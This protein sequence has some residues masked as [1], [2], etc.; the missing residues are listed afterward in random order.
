MT[1]TRPAFFFFFLFFLVFT[2]ELDSDILPKLSKISHVKGNVSGFSRC[3]MSESGL[4]VI[5]GKENK[6]RKV[7]GLLRVTHK[8]EIKPNNRNREG[9]I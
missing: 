6:T 3:A 4:C 8:I 7:A 1:R 2:R 5:A 9:K